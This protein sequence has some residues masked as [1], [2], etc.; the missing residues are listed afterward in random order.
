MRNFTAHSKENRTQMLKEIGVSSIDELFEKI[1]QA[2]RVNKLN[3]PDAISEMEAQKEL[4]RLASKNRINYISF[5]GGGAEKHFVPA[6]VSQI[7]QR[8]EFNTAY[9]PYQPE[10]SQGTLQMIYEYQSMIC[11]LC[12]MDVANASVYDGAQACAEALLMAVR[13]TNINRVLIQNSL[14]PEYKMVVETYLNAQ[15]IE[16][17]YFDSI[18]TIKEMEQDYACVLVQN[19]NYYGDIEDLSLV[20]NIFAGK[21]TLLIV[22]ANILSLSLLKPPVEYGAD[23][24]VGDVQVFG[25]AVN[26]GGP[27]GGFIACLDKYKRQLAGRI[28][29][30]TL[31]ADGNQ[32]FTLTLQTREQHIRREKATSN[33]CSNQGLVA[34][35][36]A[37]Y[38][39]VMGKDGVKQAAYLS[40]KNAHM[41]ADGLKKNGIK[42]LNKNFFNEFVIEVENSDDFLKKM[43]AKNILAGI[44]LDDKKVLVTVTEMNTEEEIE[45][46]LNR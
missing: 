29:G 26:F 34:L 1:P 10:I 43:K 31:D 17:K 35:C 23:I 22:C 44:K 41:L 7:A 15:E 40:A 13:I 39:T 11:N 5:I 38:M 3:L 46:Y 9:T 18:N 16:Y 8:F 42:I 25:S 37:V 2:A 36:A 30:R 24:V 45:R 4:R 6:C 20:K 19:P 21:K 33:I 28:V 14:N 12:G 32:A 27:Y